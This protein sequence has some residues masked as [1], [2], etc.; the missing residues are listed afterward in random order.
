VGHVLEID[1][2]ILPNERTS[3]VI[4]PI[5]LVSGGLRY[6]LINLNV[7]NWT[8]LLHQYNESK[9][10]ARQRVAKFVRMCSYICLPVRWCSYKARKRK[11]YS[12]TKNDWFEFGVKYSNFGAG[13]PVPPGGLGIS[14][15][16]KIFRVPLAVRVA[17]AGPLTRFGSRWLPRP[18]H[19]YA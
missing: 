11:V 8:S 15:G 7:G 6:V 1:N 18:Q 2:Y 5:I 4:G 13:P 9:R 16:K 12:G 14:A 3:P 17:L 19:F 10:G